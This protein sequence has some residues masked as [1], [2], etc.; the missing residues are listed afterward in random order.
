VTG[1]LPPVILAT[2]VKV[3]NFQEDIK[4]FMKSI[5]EFR[6]T[7]DMIKLV[8]REMADYSAIMRFLHVPP[9]VDESREGLH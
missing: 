5:F 1:R 4:T 3:L 6:T 8:T 7:R 9:Q 2:S